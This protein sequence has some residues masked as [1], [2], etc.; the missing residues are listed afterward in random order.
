ME[1]LEPAGG[2]DN[3]RLVAR[4]DAEFCLT[5]VLHYLVARD[6]EDLLPARFV[7]VVGQ[8]SPMAGLVAADSPL[9]APADLGGRR[10][11]GPPEGRLLV[12]YRA[13]LARRGIAEPTVVAC[14]YGQA[15]A[16]L[17]RGEIDVVP[18]FA[19]LLPRT[20]RQAG[21]D[22]R[23]VPIGAEVYASG[24]VA[25]DHVDHEVAVRM[26]EAVAAALARQ[27]HAPDNGL[28]VLRQRYPGV[29]ADEAVEGWRLVEAA[30]FTG[31]PV[32]SMQP[33]RWQASVEHYTAGHDLAA[34]DPTTTYRSELVMDADATALERSAE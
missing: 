34:P 24:V 18:D 4:A 25:G 5:S 10:V 14:D 1:I 27:R 3:I 21:I 9:H 33:E 26:R 32:A 16:A 20:R 12:E 29:D 23:A 31:A 2:P 22:L 6:E 11:G 7:A 30:I 13:C 8:R 17:G 19:D 15:P 28:D